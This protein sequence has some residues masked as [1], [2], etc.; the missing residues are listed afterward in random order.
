MDDGKNG[1]MSTS[2]YT[3]GINSRGKRP[4]QA[5]EA[6]TLLTFLRWHRETLGLKCDGLQPSQLAERAVGRSRLSLLGLV[7][8]A[9][10]TER[11][12]FRRV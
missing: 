12:W 9:T 3:N 6:T 8:H 7:R 1:G 2:P 4:S 10:E 5:D 11:F